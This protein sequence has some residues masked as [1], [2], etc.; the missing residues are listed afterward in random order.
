MRKKR[1][2]NRKRTRRYRRKTPFDRQYDSLGYPTQTILPPRKMFKLKYVESVTATSDSGTP[3]NYVYRGNSIY[4]PRYA[5]GGHQVL[6]HDQLE[7]VYT[8]YRVHGCRFKV[9]FQE[10]T[11]AVPAIM[12][13]KA[14]KV[15]GSPVGTGVDELLEHQDAKVGYTSGNQGNA[16]CVLSKYIS[17]KKL[18]ALQSISQEEQLAADM[19]SDPVT[20]WYFHWTLQAQNQSST[21]AGNATFELTYYVECFDP[22]E[23]TPS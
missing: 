2:V 17:T 15:A 20:A 16:R 12:S 19:S 9:T 13:I 21:V 11:S 8:Y 3:V 1:P 6:G 4:D 18:L 23:L 22:V 7:L 10:S 14:S 5:S